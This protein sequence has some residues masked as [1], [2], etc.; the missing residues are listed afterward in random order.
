MSRKSTLVYRVRVHRPLDVRRQTSPRFANL[1]LLFRILFAA[2]LQQFF[3]L[4]DF[5]RNIRASTAIRVVEEHKLPV[6]R[7]DLVLRQGSFPVVETSK[8]TVVLQR[9]GE[10]CL[11]RTRV[12][13][14]RRPRDGSCAVRNRL[15]RMLCRQSRRRLGIVGKQPDRLVP[16][17]LKSAFCAKRR[18]DV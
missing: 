18:L 8:P 9:N 11:G 4:V 10:M 1:S 7:A 2:L 14:S 12:I 3:R 13:R 16:V 15:C 17:S 6:I 5:R